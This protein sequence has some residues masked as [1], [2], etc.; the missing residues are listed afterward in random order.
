M[1]IHITGVE[2]LFIAQ[3]AFILR[4]LTKGMCK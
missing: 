1:G 4:N 2:V 3:D